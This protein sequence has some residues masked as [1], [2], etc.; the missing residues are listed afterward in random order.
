LGAAVY[1]GLYGLPL[2]SD[3]FSDETSGWPQESQLDWTAGYHEGA[4][5][6]LLHGSAPS[7]SGLVWSE[8]PR[9]NVAVEADV[10]LASGDPS[11]AEI[12]VMCVSRG[13]GGYVFS[14]GP[15]SSFKI[16]GYGPGAPTWMVIAEGELPEGTGLGEEPHRIR[17]ECRAGSGPA[18]VTMYVDGTK[19]AEADVTGLG[20]TS[21]DSIG[22]F[23]RAHG[24]PPPN[25][26]ARFDDALAIAVEPDS[27]PPSDP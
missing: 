4:Y 11:V 3:D 13:V 19:V 6:I 21:F 14:I 25:V 2:V 23:A 26:D 20:P 15:G 12:G 17:G 24:D 8:G 22:L 10:F 9:P 7:F 18:K 27:R 1:L 16:E 5:R